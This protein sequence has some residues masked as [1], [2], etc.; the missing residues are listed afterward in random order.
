[1]SALEKGGHFTEAA[2]VA[3]ASAYGELPEAERRR[4]A[5]RRV[6]REYTRP[7]S[8]ILGKNSPVL[9]AIDQVG[10]KGEPKCNAGKK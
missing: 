1:M 4:V 3:F 2:V 9:P 7:V 8:F 5:P 6:G 10:E